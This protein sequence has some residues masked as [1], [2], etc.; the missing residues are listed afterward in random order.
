MKDF[1]K[2]FYQSKAWKKCRQA[3]ISKRMGIDGGLCEVCGVE[4]G[5]IVHHVIPLTEENINN[6][7]ITL[8]HLNLKYE[9]KQCH[10]EEEGHYLD[11]KGIK[12]PLCLFDEEGNIKADLRRGL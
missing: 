2:S 3:Y 7:V 1:A 9:C 11:G 4:Q 12:R 8:N 6:P 10:D 5:Y